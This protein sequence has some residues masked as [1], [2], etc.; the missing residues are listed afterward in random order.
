MPQFVDMTSI[1]EAET[2]NIEKTL[3]LPEIDLIVVEIK[4]PI[5][6]II[7]FSAEVAVNRPVD[8]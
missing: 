5:D 4:D 7:S 6:E 3:I 8:F 1:G 2:S